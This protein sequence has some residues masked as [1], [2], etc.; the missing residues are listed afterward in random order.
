MVKNDQ[1]FK[2]LLLVQFWSLFQKVSK[3]WEKVKVNVLKF[4]VK[5]KHITIYVWQI[6]TILYTCLLTE[7]HMDYYIPQ[8]SYV[9]A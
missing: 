9:V 6:I 2:G 1:N 5:I 3:N 4:E 7:V 8:Y